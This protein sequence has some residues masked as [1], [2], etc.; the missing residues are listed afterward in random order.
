MRF[1]NSSERANEVKVGNSSGAANQAPSASF[2]QCSNSSGKKI[3]RARQQELLDATVQLLYRVRREAGFTD[4]AVVLDLYQRRI[5]DG[6]H[7]DTGRLTD[8]MLFTTH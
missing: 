2:L 5:W 7:H 4:G 1:Y 3:V 8:A 6:S